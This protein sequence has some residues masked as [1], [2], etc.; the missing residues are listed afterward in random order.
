[1][2]PKIRWRRGAFGLIAALLAGVGGVM[3]F[4]VGG[5]RTTAAVVAAPEEAV[6]NLGVGA[7]GRVEPE[8]GL[9]N[10]GA[11]T[12]DL[13]QTLLVHRGDVVEKGQVLAYLQ[14]YA[15][16]AAQ[17]E[18]IGA[19]LAE[20]RLKLA[21]V[22]QLDQARIDDAE[23]K[24]RQ[25]DQVEPLKIVAQEQT[26][27]SLR[28]GLINDRDILDADTQ[29]MRTNV[30]ARRTHDNEQT[31]VKQD[32]ANLEAAQDRLQ[33]LQQQYAMDQA[34]A[35][36]QIKISKADL[37]E[38]Q[39]EIPIAS[40]SRQL[41]LAKVRM[42]DATIWAPIG[43][44]IL[45]VLAHPGEQVGQI[46]GKPILT[47]GDTAGM[48]I[49]AEIY[50]TDIGRVRLGA[51]VTATSRALDRPI[52]GRV[53]EIGDLIYKNDVLNVDPAARVDAR[54]IEVRIELD[55]PQRT[56]KLSNLT[57]DVR[58]A[59]SGTNGS[60]SKPPKLATAPVR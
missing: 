36:S 7:L 3:L 42:H 46:D 18:V 57:V 9:I 6:S 4:A 2:S 20:A 37:A 40:L 29:L 15:E 52:T 14:S 54:I 49:V 44:R 25:I 22:V 47:M 10:V 16:Q 45:N 50:E 1:M 24:L 23:I 58:I 39:S 21:A 17:Y 13:L 32:K 60:P 5:V 43:G 28:K 38:A 30:V 35:Q 26:A 11:A 19:Q 59:G 48:R 55:D 8:G 34:V 53:V 51:R 41:E 27:R 33:E 12:P 56:S 31:L